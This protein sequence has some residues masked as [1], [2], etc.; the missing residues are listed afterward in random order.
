MAPAQQRTTERGEAGM[1]MPIATP[2]P[3]A[4]PT[5][6][7]KLRGGALD[8]L[9]WSAEIDVG[10]RICCGKGAW[11]AS[12]VYVVTADVI[13]GRDGLV[14]NIAVPAEF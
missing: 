1:S 9:S 11:A 8:G 12:H 5:R 2:T 3:A 14:E 6:R 10:G 13:Q 7:L 4:R